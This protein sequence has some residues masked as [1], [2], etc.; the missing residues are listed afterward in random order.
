MRHMMDELINN[1]QPASQTKIAA[2]HLK[3]LATVGPSASGKST[4]MR[5]LAT[6]DPRFSLAI[7]ESSRPQRPNENL[8]NDMIHRDEAEIVSDLKAGNLFQ[9]VT[10]PNGHLYCTRPQDFHNEKINLY[11]L[12]PLGVRQFRA[13][14]LQFFATAF[15]VPAS[16]ESW[17][18]W[19]DVQA[20]L[21]GWSKDQKT[22]RLAE[23]KKSYEFALH[24]KDMHFVLND[25]VEKAAGRLKQVGLGHAPDDEEKAREIA[26]E[27]FA[28]LI[29]I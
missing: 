3:M 28:K 5:A 15:I 22:G 11:P 6:A 14:K 26:Q 20:R 27:N 21:S 12:I 24:D 18:Q 7:G 17:L 25:E 9:V 13:L 4:I 19:L 8:H 2:S 16:F 23:A 10:G 1:Y 29:K